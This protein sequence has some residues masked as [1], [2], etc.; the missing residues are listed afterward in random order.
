MK[1]ND[2]SSRRLLG[3]VV[4]LLLLV[5]TVVTA[6]PSTPTLAGPPDPPIPQPE[7]FHIRLE[8]PLTGPG[9]AAEP[10]SAPIHVAADPGEWYDL[11]AETFEDS[12]FPPDGWESTGNGGWP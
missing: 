7:P 8:Q 3:P 2:Q 11:M 6:M 1:A 12:T 4:A 5:G 9:V 10:L